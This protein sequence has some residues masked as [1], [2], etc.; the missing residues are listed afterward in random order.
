MQV[1]E[2]HPQGAP[3]PEVPSE[4]ARVRLGKKHSPQVPGNVDTAG[5]RIAPPCSKAYTEKY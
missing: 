3:P 2:P 1:R 5:P 4:Q